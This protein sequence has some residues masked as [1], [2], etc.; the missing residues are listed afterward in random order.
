MGTCGEYFTLKPQQNL[1]YFLFLVL[2]QNQE[3]N[4]SPLPQGP[5]VLCCPDIWQWGPLVLYDNFQMCGPKDTFSVYKF[6]YLVHFYNNEKLA[7]T[8]FLVLQVDFLF[9]KYL[10][11]SM[12]LFLFRFLSFIFLLYFRKFCVLNCLSKSIRV[13]K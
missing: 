12:L 4:R 2:I 3:V 8:N 7:T 9:L 13:L 10:S 11:E 5:M 1:G 6:V